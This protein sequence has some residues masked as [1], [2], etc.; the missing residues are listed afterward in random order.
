MT[1]P[2]G[3]L[4]SSTIKNAYNGYGYLQGNISVYQYFQGQPTSFVPRSTSTATVRSDA[5]RPVEP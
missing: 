5:R 4:I 2:P 3:K 1:H